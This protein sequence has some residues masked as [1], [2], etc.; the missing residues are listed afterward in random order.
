MPIHAGY[1][2]KPKLKSGGGLPKAKGG[3]SCGTK[4]RMKGLIKAQGGLD[5]LSMIPATQRRRR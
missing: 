5:F 3:G 2:I 1:K 4:G